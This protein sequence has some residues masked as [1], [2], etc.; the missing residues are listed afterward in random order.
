MYALV[1][2]NPE[3]HYPKLLLFGEIFGLL[4]VIAVGFL[5]NENVSAN[6]YNWQKNPFS[7]HPLMMTL[8]LMFCYGNAILLYRTFRK[9]PKLIVK[10]CHALFLLI[11]FACGA[12]GF[13]AIFRSKQLGQRPHFMTF[14]SWLGLA[15]LVFI[16]LTMDLWFRL[17]LSST[18]EFG[19]SSSIY[20]KSS[21]LG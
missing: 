3:T 20:A 19:Y 7:Y 14:H 10:I 18:I 11:S 4:S 5:F 21:T 15:T 1:G 12:V 13:T 9:S 8:G 2:R 16:Y 6:T 17:L